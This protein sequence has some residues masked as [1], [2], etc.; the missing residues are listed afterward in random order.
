[1]LEID[2]T[3]HR[4]I[5]INVYLPFLCKINL[6]KVINDYNEVLGFIEFIMSENVDAE[7]IVLGDFNC[8]FYDSKHPFFA[9]LTDFTSSHNLSSAFVLSNDFQLSNAYTRFDARSKSLIDYI[10]ISQGIRHL[11]KNVCIFHDPE[12]VSDHLPVEVDLILSFSNTGNFKRTKNPF[13]IMWS[14]LS[15]E[16]DWLF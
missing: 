8:E 14:K 2:C 15:C 11:I 7:F 1:M 12:N 16:Q 9:S 3:P 10:F 6:Q 4:I 13:N 5:L